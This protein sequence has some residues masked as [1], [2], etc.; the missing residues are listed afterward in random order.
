MSVSNRAIIHKLELSG[1]E[2]AFIYP[3]KVGLQK[4]IMDATRPVRAFL[5][6]TDLHDFSRQRQGKDGKVI[7]NCDYYYQNKK[8]STRASLYRPVTKNG[9]PRIWIYGLGGE[10]WKAQPNDELL[11]V[12]HRDELIVFNCNTFDLER[13]QVSHDGIIS[14]VL[15][16]SLETSATADELMQRL[17]DIYLKGHVPSMKSGS[18]GIGFTL[19]SL[20]DIE[21]NSS[22]QPDYKGIELKATRKNGSTSRRNNLFCKTPDWARSKHSA[23]SLLQTFGYTS[24]TNIQ[25]LEVT[26]RAD[27]ANRQGLILHVDSDRDDLHTLHEPSSDQVLVWALDTLRTRLQEKHAETFWVKADTQRSSTTGIEA[28]NYF[29]VTHTKAP[30]L[31]TFERLLANG[32]ISLDLMMKEKN[33]ATKAVRDRGYSFKVS[34]SNFDK[35]FP[36]IQVQDFSAY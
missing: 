34:G 23:W 26:V 27:K 35:L 16:S 13:E 25:R 9:D 11:L 24:K 8:F 3:T 29:H 12:A 33:R 36:I 30:S 4:G 32:G 14:Q 15:S 2:I 1:V 21:A 28:F 22:T 18:T 19:E 31:V 20:L 5:T 6:E 7:I 10:N 17:H